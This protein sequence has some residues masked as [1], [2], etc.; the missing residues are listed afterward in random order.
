MDQ[1]SIT[2]DQFDDEVKQR[3]FQGNYFLLREN[4]ENYFLRALKVRRL[5]IEDFKNVFEKQK[6]DLLL[7]PVTKQEAPRYSEFVDES[8]YERF[9]LEDYLTQAVNMAGLPAISLP[10]K[11]SSNN[12]PLSLQLISP[13]YSDFKLLNIAK[14]L[15][16]H[17]NFP[18]LV[19]DDS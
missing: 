12:L 13:I 19:Y 16:K 18:L 7:T 3:I 8:N 15:E 4:Y 14:Q 11:L 5:I 6:F 17:F 1:Y 2:R 9:A 10:A